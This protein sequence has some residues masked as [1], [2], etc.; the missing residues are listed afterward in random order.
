[1]SADHYGW[2]ANIYVGW[3]R[4]DDGT[5]T[6]VAIKTMR[7][8]HEDP[9]E[10]KRRLIIET[11]VWVDLDH[12]NILKFLGLAPDLG[13]YGVPALVSPYCEKGTVDD[14]LRLHPNTNTKLFI[15]KGV[16]SGLQY[17]HQ[18]DV[19]HGNL[20]PSSILIYDDGRALLCGFGSSRILTQQSPTKLFVATRYD[21]P[22]FIGSN[23]MGPNKPTDV[24]SF[25]MTCYRIWTNTKPFA[26]LASDSSVIVAV[27][28]EQARPAYPTSDIPPGTDLVWKILE[29]CWKTEAE[30]RL[31]VSVAMERLAK[32]NIPA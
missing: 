30:K 24:Y 1:M 8:S 19:V 28:L 5:R 3:L 23:T 13:S 12:P 10:I 26:D 6:R 2:R 9:I 17:L 32:I 20:K 22:E 18:R 4:G 7:V 31:E 29:D 25:A 27:I 16:A 14:Y 15:I 11:A 21:A